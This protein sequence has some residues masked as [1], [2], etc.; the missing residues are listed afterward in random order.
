MQR[1]LLA[2]S[3]LMH[4]N[5]IQAYVRLDVRIDHALQAP[6]CSPKTFFN[7]KFMGFCNIHDRKSAPSASKE[8]AGKQLPCLVSSRLRLVDIFCS[9]STA[10]IPYL[11]RSQ[12]AVGA[13]KRKMFEPSLLILPLVACS[14]ASIILVQ[15]HTHHCLCTSQAVSVHFQKVTQVLPEPE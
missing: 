15:S 11:L 6:P 4:W 5:I 13:V 10:Y 14:K 3:A 8:E 2:H 12:A 1:A 9:G 7:L